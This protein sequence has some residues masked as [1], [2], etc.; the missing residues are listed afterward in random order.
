M[1]GV[2]ADGDVLEGLESGSVRYLGLYTH[3]GVNE[4][5]VAVPR[6]RQLD[7][8]CDPPQVVADRVG[9][10]ERLTEPVSQGA[11]QFA[12]EGLG[13]WPVGPRMQRRPGIQ[14]LEF[15]MDEPAWN[16]DKEIDLARL[17]LGVSD[18]VR[19][20]GRFEASTGKVGA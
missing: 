14:G 17:A 3:H 4:S 20:H 15:Q 19:K 1:V 10:V 2:T 8:S 9:G 16:P 11:G 7:R 18:E 5:V 13:P 6:V 12:G